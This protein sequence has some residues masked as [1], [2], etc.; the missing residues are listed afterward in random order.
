MEREV[1]ASNPLD[2]RTDAERIQQVCDLYHQEQLWADH[3]EQE[4]ENLKK[5][6][7]KPG[8]DLLQRTGLRTDWFSLP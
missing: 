4:V 2:E 7:K 6:K 8:R 5:E 1:G 3:L